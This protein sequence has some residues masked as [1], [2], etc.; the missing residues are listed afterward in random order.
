MSRLL[1]LIL[2]RKPMWIVP[3]ISPESLS[4]PMWMVLSVLWTGQPA[5]GMV[6]RLR[7]KESF[8]FL[9][10]STDE[11]YGSLEAGEPPFTEKSP[12]NPKS[13]YSSSKASADFIVWSYQNTYGLPVL[14]TNTCNNYGPFQY[15]EKLVPLMIV[16][17]LAGA[18]LP[19]YGD[20]LNVRDWIYVGDNVSAIE[21]VLLKGIPGETYNIGAS[22]EK[23]NIELVKNICGILQKLCPLTDGKSYESLIRHVK[24]R[25]GHDRRYS[26]DSTK[27][28]HELGWEPETSFGK[29]LGLTVG[30]YLENPEWIESVKT[31]EYKNWVEKNYGGGR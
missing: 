5:I 11:V 31:K 1:L 18:E 7:K 29:G 14:V 15:P 26:I 13:P 3:Y 17:A 25:P 30:W 27:I 2:P 19:V 10:V 9:H 16:N 6:F 22:C 23:T 24:D 20:G 4:K 8:R 12:Y 21:R 28:K